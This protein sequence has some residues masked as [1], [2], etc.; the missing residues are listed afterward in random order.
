MKT[1][2][3]DT[4]GRLLMVGAL[5]GSFAIIGVINGCTFNAE[6]NRAHWESFKRDTREAHQFVDR[7]FFNYDWDDP[8][9]WYIER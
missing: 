5:I 2:L 4:F 3:K 7:T 6:H 8:E 9:N 1:A